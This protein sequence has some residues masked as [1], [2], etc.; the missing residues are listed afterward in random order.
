MTLGSLLRD[1]RTRMKLS[2][3]EVERRTG[4]SN[5]YLSLLE[6]GAARRPSPEFLSK[7]AAL[8]GASYDLLMELAGY[9]APQ[10]P[11]PARAIPG[12]EELEDLSMIELEQLRAFVGYLRSTR[13]ESAAEQANSPD[14]QPN[15]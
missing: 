6:T 1:A 9:Q 3:R 2:L 7:L 13:T 14:E 11:T 5:G 8:Y 10:A 4:I 15:A 12:L